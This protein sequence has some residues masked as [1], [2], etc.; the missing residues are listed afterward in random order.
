MQALGSAVKSNESYAITDLKDPK[1]RR[2]PKRGLYRNREFH[3]PSLS[4][5]Y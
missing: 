1:I 2:M 3:M 5:I 4:M